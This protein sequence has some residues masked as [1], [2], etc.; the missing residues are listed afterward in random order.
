[1]DHLTETTVEYGPWHDVHVYVETA[2]NGTSM[3]TGPVYDIGH[4]SDCGCP[5]H[6]SD[7]PFE[8]EFD[9]AADDSWPTRGEFRCRTRTESWPEPAP[10]A[11][12]PR[13]EFEQVVQWEPLAKIGGS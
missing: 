8:D 13:V 11:N 3:H 2:W 4:T 10:F 5:P 1:M 9:D 12:G 7:C 6:G